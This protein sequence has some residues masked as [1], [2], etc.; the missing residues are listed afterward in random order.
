[1]SFGYPIF[2]VK[3]MTSPTEQ[4][5]VVP[6]KIAAHLGDLVSFSDSYNDMLPSKQRELSAVVNNLRYR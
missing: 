1:M 6:D 3:R 2:R 5:H 4:L